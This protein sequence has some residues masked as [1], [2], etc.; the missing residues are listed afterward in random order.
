VHFH[1]KAIQSRGD[2]PSYA[3]PYGIY[4]AVIIYDVLPEPPSTHAQLT[5][6]HLATRTPYRINFSLAERGKTAYFAIAWQNEKG[7]KGPFGPIV[8]EIIP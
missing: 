4:G 6:H 3:K 5:K 8:S 7:E 2:K 1:E